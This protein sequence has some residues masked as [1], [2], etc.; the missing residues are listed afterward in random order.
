MDSTVYTRDGKLPGNAV[1]E[2]FF[3][4]LKS[5]LLYPETCQSGEQFQQKFVA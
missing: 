2:N 4:L 3:A 1:R 5:E